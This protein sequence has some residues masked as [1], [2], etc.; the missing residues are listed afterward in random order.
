[1]LALSCSRGE[2][3]SNGAKEPAPARGGTVDETDRKAETTPEI[4]AEAEKILERNADEPV[5]TEIP[6]T[7]NGRRYVA[8]IEQHESPEKGEHKGVTVYHAP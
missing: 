4:I 6:F 1:L 8:R 3:A 7:L 2:A 5:G